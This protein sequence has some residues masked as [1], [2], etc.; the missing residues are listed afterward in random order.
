MTE[1]I[2]DCPHC[3]ARDFMSPGA[4]CPVCGHQPVVERVEG[5]VDPW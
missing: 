1:T 4:P 5:E 2:A 3:G